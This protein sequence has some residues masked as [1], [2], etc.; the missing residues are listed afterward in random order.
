MNEFKIVVQPA[1]GFA[2]GV[3]SPNKAV[4]DVS[5]M[6][7]LPVATIV[8]IAMSL[9]SLVIKDSAIVAK[10]QAVVDLLLPLFQKS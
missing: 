4:V 10:I 8:Q 1:E 3:E 6:A 5:S 7:A 2:A 9:L